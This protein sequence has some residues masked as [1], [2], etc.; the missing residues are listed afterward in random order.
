MKY[1]PN[2]RS[3]SFG[4]VGLIPSHNHDVRAA[5]VLAA[6]APVKVSESDERTVPALDLADMGHLAENMQD[7][8]KT[9][10]L[11]RFALAMSVSFS[12][13]ENTPRR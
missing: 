11:S 2:N 5:P 1:L 7:L 13:S 9:T 3:R 12:E 6:R 8:I 10:G 4:S